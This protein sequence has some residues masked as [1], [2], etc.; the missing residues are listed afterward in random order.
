MVFLDI[1]LH[2]RKVFL[3]TFA[4]QEP[5][6]R[7]ETYD[8]QYAAKITVK[9]PARMKDIEED[10]SFEARISTIFLAALDDA[11]DLIIAQILKRWNEQLKIEI[12]NSKSS[13]R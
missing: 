10:R 2:C 4:N 6:K 9:K 7:Y 5:G 3:E 11:K 13:S 1:Y 12:S 8:A